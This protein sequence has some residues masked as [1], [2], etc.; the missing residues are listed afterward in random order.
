MT[1]VPIVECAR[2]AQQATM[3]DPA[4][5]LAF[6]LDRRLPPCPVGRPQSAPDVRKEPAR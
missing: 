1:H 6:H 4:R 3:Y 5:G 2:C